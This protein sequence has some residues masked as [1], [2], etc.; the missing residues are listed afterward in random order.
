MANIRP[1]ALR[2]QVGPVG[3]SE[4]AKSRPVARILVDTGV[5]HLD[6]PYDY[7]VPEK[8]SHIVEIGVRVEVPFGSSLREGIVLERLS[9]SGQS[10][11][12]KEISKVLSPFPIATQLS[13]KLLSATATRWAGVPYDVLRSAIPP[14]A[15][16]VDAVKADEANKSLLSQSQIILGKEFFQAEVRLFWSLPPRVAVADL[17]VALIES[18]LPFGQV[19]IL[20]PDL[21]TLQRLESALELRF[22]PSLFVRI[23]GHTSRGDRYRNYLAMIG[24]Q[25]RIALALRGGIFTP[26]EVGSSL[27]VLDESSHHYYEVRT[28][29]WNVRD[30][31]LI[32]AT[33]EGINLIFAGYSPSLEISRMIDS[34]WLKLITSKV[35]TPVIASQG[36]RGELIPSPIFSLVRR[37]LKKGP[38]LFLVPLRGYGNAILCN[39]CRNFA[40]CECGGRLQKSSARAEPQCAICARIYLDWRCSWCAS[41]EIYVAARGIER[42]AEEIG[43]SF[44]NWPLY[45]S[46]G[47]HI[48]DS[49]ANSPAL[50]ISTPG[51][52]PVVEHGYAAVVLLQGMRFFGHSEL[53]SNER[54][55][56][57]FFDCAARISV[58]GEIGLVIDSAHP[59]VAALTTWDPTNMVRRELLEREDAKLPPFSRVVLLEMDK[60]ESSGI[61]SGLLRARQELRI[62]ISC[63]IQGPYQRLNGRSRIT[64]SAPIAQAEKLVSFIHEL[65]RKRSISKKPLFNI[66]VDPYSLE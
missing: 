52:T 10:G 62:P 26:L 42:F 51:A 64:L 50:V 7:W 19:L 37:A 58:Q 60:D 35:R 54:A 43:K 3:I 28:P 11:K 38:V 21:R 45:N 23:D 14:R 57:L 39:K 30:V 22:D 61:Y 32:R 25:A 18:R 56:E 27:I 47:E 41:Q 33:S 55:R 5:F 4:I 2:R 44:P 53:H 20:A 16:F 6:A 40:L 65:Q 59:I 15:K 31:S 9:E 8:L 49:V 36:H 48:I 12:L 46:A 1:L 66:R 63:Q 17:V 24:G 34:G 29:G 13:M